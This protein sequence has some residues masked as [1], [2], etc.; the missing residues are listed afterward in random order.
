MNDQQVQYAVKLSKKLMGLVR[1]DKDR[2]MKREEL[3][4]LATD[5]LFFQTEFVKVKIDAEQAFRLRIREIIEKEGT[6]FAAAENKAMT[7]ECYVIYKKIN[8]IWDL[9]E[10][11][12]RLLKIMLGSSY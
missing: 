4:N 5:I 1:A 8:H 9:A 2:Q 11:K 10:E 3:E 12:I 7:E 6:S